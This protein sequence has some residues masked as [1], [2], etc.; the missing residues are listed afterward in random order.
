[1]TVR[2]SEE[3]RSLKVAVEVLGIVYVRAH[4]GETLRLFDPSGIA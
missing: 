3:S 1:M 4:C 2:K